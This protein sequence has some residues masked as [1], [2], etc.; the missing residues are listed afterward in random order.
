MND[1]MNELDMLY[2]YIKIRSVLEKKNETLRH[3]IVTLHMSRHWQIV[4]I[5]KW[6]KTSNYQK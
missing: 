5:V 1:F 3:Q 6:L 2:G 4:K